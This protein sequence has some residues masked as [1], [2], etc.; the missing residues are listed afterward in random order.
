MKSCWSPIGVLWSPAGILWTLLESRWTLLDSVGVQLEY[1]GVQSDYIG[2]LWTILDL[3]GVCRSPH[4]VSR[5]LEESSRLHWNTWASVKSWVAAGI[6]WFSGQG[7]SSNP[8]LSSSTPHHPLWVIQHGS[9]LSAS[10]VGSRDLIA[11]ARPI[12]A[13][14]PA[15]LSLLEPS[16]P[17]ER[18][19]SI[20]QCCR[21]PPVSSKR[22]NQHLWPPSHSKAITGRRS[23]LERLLWAFSSAKFSFFEI[24]LSRPSAV[25]DREGLDGKRTIHID[26]T[27]L[28]WR[29]CA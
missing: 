24:P 5:S 1:A 22:R 13:C 14:F 16:G 11:P 2:V 6:P 18:I 15:R 17:R 9:T 28:Y 3:V 19:I 29:L 20:S 21:R 8:N 27:S 25:L 12:I 4:R 23:W 10:R 26:G 7:L